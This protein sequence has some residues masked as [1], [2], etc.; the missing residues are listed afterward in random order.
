MTLAQG[1]LACMRWLIIVLVAVSLSGCTGGSD[2]FFIEEVN[3]SARSVQTATVLLDVEAVVGADATGDDWVLRVRA[4]DGRT[5]L[6]IASESQDLEKVEDARAGVFVVPIEVPREPSVRLEVQLLREHIVER[7]W[8]L[9]V[10]QLDLLPPDVQDV[11]VRVDHTDLNVRGVE[12]GRVDLGAT[13]YL[14]N[15]GKQASPPLQAQVV[16][17]EVTTRMVTDESWLAVEPVPPGATAVARVDLDLPDEQEY[18][19]ETTLWRDSFIVGR[20]T[21][22][23]AFGNGTAVA[24]SIDL[25]YDRD[26]DDDRGHHGDSA[27]EGD[28]AASPGLPLLGLAAVLA[29]AAVVVRRRS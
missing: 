6:L 23:L 28:D 27:G 14:T 5:G 18:T 10:Q 13:L 1:L 8:N 7:F 9:H 25:V 11:G 26:L 3:V 12:A 17:R 22:S 16:V 24:R 4:H 29:V 20:S 21:E 19:I 2:G 15:E